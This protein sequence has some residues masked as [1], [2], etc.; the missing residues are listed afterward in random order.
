[1]GPALERIGAEIERIFGNPNREGGRAEGRKGGNQAEAD[2]ALPPDRPTAAESLLERRERLDRELRR[3][4]E[5]MGVVVTGADVARAVGAAVG[6]R[7][8]WT[9]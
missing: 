1:I 9:A 4:L 7:I 2:T 3:G 8:E 5:Q 6:K